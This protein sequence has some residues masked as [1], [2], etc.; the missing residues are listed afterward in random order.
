[1]N[2]ELLAKKIMETV[3]DVQK[4]YFTSNSVAKEILDKVEV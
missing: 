3:S 4:V 2:G 1:M